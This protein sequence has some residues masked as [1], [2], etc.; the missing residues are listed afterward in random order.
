VASDIGFVLLCQ[1]AFWRRIA[2]LIPGARSL[3]PDPWCTV[4]RTGLAFLIA[5]ATGVALDA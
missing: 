4:P 5:S 1:I 2:D 3:V